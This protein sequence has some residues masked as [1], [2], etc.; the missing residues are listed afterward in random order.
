MQIFSQVAK[1]SFSRD[2]RFAGSAAR[3][4]SRRYSSVTDRNLPAAVGDP[5]RRGIEHFDRH[6]QTAP[7]EAGGSASPG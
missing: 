6:F 7:V 4:R 1:S 5:F 2:A 3:M